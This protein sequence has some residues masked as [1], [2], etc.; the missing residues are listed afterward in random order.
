MQTY[1]YVLTSA[2]YKA[3]SELNCKD[4]TFNRAGFHS[5]VSF[6]QTAT[7]NNRSLFSKLKFAIDDLAV[8][9]PKD[10]KVL[11]L[12]LETY[13]QKLIKVVDLTE[14]HW[15]F[16]PW[17]KRE[18][19]SP[20]HS[21]DIS[22]YVDNY[23]DSFSIYLFNNEIL[24]IAEHLDIPLKAVKELLIRE[25]AEY[26]EHL[27][28]LRLYIYDKYDIIENIN[29]PETSFINFKKY[30]LK[31]HVYKMTRFVE[32]DQEFINFIIASFTCASTNQSSYNKNNKYVIDYMFTSKQNTLK[33]ALIAFLKKVNVKYE[34][35]ENLVTVKNKPFYMFLVNGLMADSDFLY[36]L[37]S[38][39]YKLFTETLFNN[40]S[41]VT[42][43]SL[44]VA[45]QI[46]HLF[47]S[48]KKVV[49]VRENP[50][51]GYDVA[52]IQDD[53]DKLDS[54]LIYSKNG[55]YS[56][57]LPIYQPSEVDSVYYYINS[58]DSEVMF[59]NCF[60]RL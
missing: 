21:I 11:S 52:L 13:E 58:E 31:N 55:Y 53:F 46:K 16:C 56:K 6:T 47:L 40:N 51:G 59:T 5:R 10:K 12:D 1:N 42:N 49:S 14:D 27:D 43:V 2:G 24:E 9:L 20:K 29:D 8:I 44:K 34:V 45:L 38:D 19:F 18:V 4:L 23:Y 30:V 37:E 3:T 36:R 50:F 25:A 60:V 22:K 35:K 7:K 28:K 41:T 33:N 26:K 32:I 15:V 17:I 54:T 57:L 48:D 39:H